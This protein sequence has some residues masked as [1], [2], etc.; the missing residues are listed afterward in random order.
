MY[1]IYM[2]LLLTLFL[3]LFFIPS[4]YS[5][6]NDD[7]VEDVPETDPGVDTNFG[8][9]PGD[10]PHQKDLDNNPNV[11]TIEIPPHPMPKL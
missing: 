8:G 3:F 2:K 4:S 5:G 10:I 1:F 6:E 11:T 9:F 7:I